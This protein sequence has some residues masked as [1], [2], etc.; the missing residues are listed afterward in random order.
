MVTRRLQQSPGKH[1]TTVFYGVFGQILQE[2]LVPYQLY[3]AVNF[4]I[5]EETRKPKLGSKADNLLMRPNLTLQSDLS[6]FAP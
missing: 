1:R 4:R 2:L 3:E 6:W 5:A